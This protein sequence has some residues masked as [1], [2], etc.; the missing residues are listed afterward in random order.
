MSGI[1]RDRFAVVRENAKAAVVNEQVTRQRVDVLEAA[2]GKVAG[3]MGRGL[4]GRLE[5]LLTGR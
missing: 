4:W 2:M 1:T 5:W 3:I